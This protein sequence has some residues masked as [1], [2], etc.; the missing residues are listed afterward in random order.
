MNTIVPLAGASVKGPLGVPFAPRMWLKCVLD[1]GSR[2]AP[3]YTAH[4]AG[5]NRLLIDGLGLDPDATFA[6]L[7][8]QP[9]YPAFEDWLR[10]HARLDAATVAATASA[11]GDRNKRSAAEAAETRARIGLAEPIENSNQLNDLDDWYSVWEAAVAARRGS[12]P[13]E[14]LVPA[15]SSQSRTLGG[16]GHLP[17]FWMKATLNAVGALYPGWK[18]GRVSGF[19][20][21][22][23]GQLGLDVDATIAYIDRELPFVLD[24]QRWVLANA[25]HA[26]PADIE[27]FNA[28]IPL[29]QKPE[30]VAAEERA[31]LGIDDPTYR[32]S[33]EM[34]DLVDW[35]MLHRIATG[36]LAETVQRL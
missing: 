6:F 2:L 9:T 32:P 27:R 11:I 22:F 4:Y 14:P 5:A 3:G 16:F 30:E 10:G 29:R 31:L 25:P 13:L 21:F 35:F 1:A 26:S 15:L 36:K 28:A 33:I 7:Q 20:M 18:S 19:D 23:C 24:F 34:N 17:R 12:A 8:T